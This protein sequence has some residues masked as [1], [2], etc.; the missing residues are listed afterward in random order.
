MQLACWFRS[1]CVGWVVLFCGLLAPAQTGVP[2]AASAQG[3]AYTIHVDSTLVQLPVLVLGTN[4][5]SVNV[6]ARRG[7]NGGQSVEGTDAEN[8]LGSPHPVPVIAPSRFRILVDGTRTIAPAVVRRQGSDRVSIAILVDHSGAQPEMLAYLPHA[9]DQAL[10]QSL[11]KDDLISAYE[12]DHC[13]LRHTL[14]AGPA[15]A[16]RVRDGVS[17]SVVHTKVTTSAEPGATPC[18]NKVHLWDAVAL[19]AKDLAQVP[20]RRVILLVSNGHD[21][22]STASALAV[23]QYS[24]ASAVTVFA[25]SDPEDT[26]RAWVARQR[27]RFGPGEEDLLA[28]LCEL[29]GGLLVSTTPPEEGTAM[30]VILNLLKERYILEFPKPAGLPPGEHLFQVKIRDFQGVVRSGGFQAP[31]R[32]AGAPSV[33]TEV[34]GATV[35]GN[36]SA[37]ASVQNGETTPH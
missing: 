34:T 12:L 1:G 3:Q 22:G 28:R 8:L 26:W 17:A 7:V 25:L 30:S 20:G 18:R 36:A 4:T 21:T 9:V 33:Q 19:V 14:V 10:T 32:D 31:V 37:P 2:E 15:D 5:A 16:K 27:P 29:S 6:A 35:P 13:T 11:R 24:V 23:R